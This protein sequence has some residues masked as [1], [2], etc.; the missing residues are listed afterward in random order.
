MGGREGVIDTAC[1][2]VTGDTKILISENNKCFQVP[3]GNFIDN[4]LDKNHKN[5]KKYDHTNANMELLNIEDK[6]I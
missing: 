6:Y 5:V 4:Y 2:S 1:K 3:I